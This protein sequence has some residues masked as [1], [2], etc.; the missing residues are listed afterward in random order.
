MTHRM[1]RCHTFAEPQPRI[2]GAGR[3][4]QQADAG[5]KIEQ[6]ARNYKTAW[7]AEMLSGR[8]ECN[9]RPGHSAGG[10]HV[11]S[12][13]LHLRLFQAVSSCFKL[14]RGQPAAAN[15]S[16]PGSRP[17]TGPLQSRQPGSWRGPHLWAGA[18]QSTYLDRSCFLSR[19]PIFCSTSSLSTTQLTRS[20]EAACRGRGW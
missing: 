6:D 10:T 1:T 14:A 2:S 19:S 12:E 9:R 11:G 16:P 8:E 18:A 15:R 20:P 17:P 3:W 7:S 4:N 13:G 5:A